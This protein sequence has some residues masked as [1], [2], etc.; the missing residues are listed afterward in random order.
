[1]ISLIS[2][3][4]LFGFV[5]LWMDSLHAKKIAVDVSRRA[6]EQR[7]F[8]LLDDTAVLKSMSLK[9]SLAGHLC[10]VRTYRFE[11]FQENNLRLASTITLAGKLVVEL[12]FSRPNNIV[13]F[14][15]LNQS[16]P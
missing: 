12:G 11:Y 9:R 16:H 4:I 1:M 10:I 14:P 2:L 6:C 5:W 3:F 8:Q 13:Q 15:N 7:H